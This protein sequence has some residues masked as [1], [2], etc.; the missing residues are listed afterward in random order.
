MRVLTRIEQVVDLV[1]KECGECGIVFAVPEW[2]EKQCL[3]DG[4]GWTCPAGHSR[5]YRDPKVKRLE[6]ELETVKA[7]EV[8]ARDQ[9][10]AAERRAAAARG[11]VTKLKN[12]VHAGVCPHCNRSFQQ[13]AR[14]MKS[15]HPEV[16]AESST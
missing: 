16:A 13:L 6:R 12:R 4:R 10:E 15:K 14:H 2:F 9:A 8:H 11:Q 3:D 1:E 7:R 5:V